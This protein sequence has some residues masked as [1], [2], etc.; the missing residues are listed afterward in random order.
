MMV[1]VMVMMVIEKEV[2]ENYQDK[3]AVKQNK[4]H[5]TFTLC[6]FNH[7]QLLLVIDVDIERGRVGLKSPIWSSSSLCQQN[8]QYRLEE[9]NCRAYIYFPGKGGYSSTHRKQ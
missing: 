9:T 7:L 5:T 4:P 3:E 6:C 2:G 8:S 1:V